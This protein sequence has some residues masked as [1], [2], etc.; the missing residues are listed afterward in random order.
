MSKKNNIEEFSFLISDNTLTLM[1]PVQKGE[2]ENAELFYNGKNVALLN[3]NS[4]NFLVLADI[5]PDVRELLLIQQTL[6]ICEVSEHEE[7]KNAYEVEVQLKPEIPNIK[8]GFAD[9]DEE[10]SFMKDIYGEDEY[11][12]IKKHLGLR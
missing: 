11:Q 3:R 2:C 1:L 7:I 8:D 6:L 12:K 5:S 10:M 9:F 4:D